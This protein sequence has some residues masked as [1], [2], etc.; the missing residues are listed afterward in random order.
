MGTAVN[1]FSAET[2]LKLVRPIT[3]RDICRTWFR[4]YNKP[5]EWRKLQGTEQQGR[6]LWRSET[7]LP[8]KMVGFLVPSSF[9]PPSACIMLGHRSEKKH[10]LILRSRRIAE[11]ILE[12]YH[13]LCRSQI[14]FL[15]YTRWELWCVALLWVTSGLGEVGVV[16][17]FLQKVNGI[18]HAIL[19]YLQ[20]FS[21]SWF[22][23]NQHLWVR[24]VSSL[25]SD[26]EWCCGKI[27]V[28]WP[29]VVLLSFLCLP[30]FILATSSMNVRWSRDP[31]WEDTHLFPLKMMQGTWVREGRFRGIGNWGC[32]MGLH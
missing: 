20:H 27:S 25:P 15:Y 11:F 9:Y 8:Q 28:F 32:V 6:K 30:F 4:P 21:S 3:V 1:F 16:C 18:T 10:V 23:S 14:S 12:V 31:F 13:F 7:C 2:K 5:L 19:V 17:F 29:F 24:S 26:V 22:D